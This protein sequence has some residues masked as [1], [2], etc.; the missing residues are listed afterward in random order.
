M[1]FKILL[2]KKNK[3]IKAFGNDKYLYFINEYGLINLKSPQRI[4]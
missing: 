2:L 1:P 4:S 3:R